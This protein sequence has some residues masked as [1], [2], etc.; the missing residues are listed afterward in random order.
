LAEAL[1]GL[2]TQRALY[3]E[4]E[5]EVRFLAPDVFRTTFFLPSDIPTGEYR[6]SVYLFRDEAFLAGSTQ[7][8][9]IAKGGFSDQLA[10]AAIDFPLPYGLVCVALAIFTGWL[11]GVVFRRT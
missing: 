2:K 4:R 9:S 8:L 6:V 1:I 10:R 7:V 5:E 3:V 11:A